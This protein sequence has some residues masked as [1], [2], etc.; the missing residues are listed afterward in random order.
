MLSVLYMF[1]AVFPPIIRISNYIYSIWY[2][3]SLLAATASV[4]ELAV[5][6]SKL[7]IYQMLHTQFEILMMGGKSAR[8]M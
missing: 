6:A 1:R 8:N 3:L 2:M 5:A 7:D 4:A